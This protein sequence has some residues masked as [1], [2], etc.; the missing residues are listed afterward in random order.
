MGRQCCYVTIFVNK[1]D[2]RGSVKE[3]ILLVIDLSCLERTRDSNWARLS[4]GTS[5]WASKEIAGLGAEYISPA[6]SRLNSLS[7]VILF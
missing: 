1:K 7:S 3:I 2:S 6:P 5:T 4:I